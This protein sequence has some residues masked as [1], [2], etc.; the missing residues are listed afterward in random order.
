MIIKFL[1]WISVSLFILHEM[2]A[3][4]TSEWKM[5]ILF[6]RMDDRNTYIVFTSLHFF[7]FVIIFYFMDYYLDYMLIIFSILFILHWIIHLIFRKHPENQMNNTFSKIL[8]SLMF[9]NS[10]VSLLYYFIIR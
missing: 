6:S 5:L 1:F 4:K 8:I 7:L 3:V 10:C 2:D 9:V